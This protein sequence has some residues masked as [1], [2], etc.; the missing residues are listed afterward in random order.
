MTSG[1]IS[2]FALRLI[3]MLLLYWSASSAG[4]L[5]PLARAPSVSQRLSSLL[6]ELVSALSTSISSHSKGGMALIFGSYASDLKRLIVDSLETTWTPLSNSAAFCHSS[7]V[8]VIVSSCLSYL[9]LRD[10]VALFCSSR[11]FWRILLWL[12][13]FARLSKRLASI[14][15]LKSLGWSMRVLFKIKGLWCLPEV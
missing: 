6:Y 15:F 1:D 8:R 3:N 5:W 9:C 7:R 10:F 2:K 12:D 13:S 11:V 14:E 4:T